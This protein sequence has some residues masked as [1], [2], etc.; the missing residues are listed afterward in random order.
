MFSKGRGKIG[1]ASIAVVMGLF[2]ASGAFQAAGAST[3]DAA[4]NNIQV[5]VQAAKSATNY[6]YTIAAYDSKGAL[7]VT[8][9]TMYPAAS[10]EVPSGAYTFTVIASQTLQS[11][12]VCYGVAQEK[13]GE[14]GA[15]SGSVGAPSAIMRPVCGGFPAAEYGFSVQQVTG[16]NTLTISTAPVDSLT[17]STFSIQVKYANGTAAEGVQ[18]SATILGAD[19][20]WP[21]SATAAMWNQTG[22]DGVATLVAPSAPLIVN[23]WSWLPVNLPNSITTIQ[24]TVG[25][26]KV[27]VT[28]YWQPTY[29]GLA[30]SALIMPPATGAQIILH[31]QQPDYWVQPYGV[32]GVGVASPP[33]VGRDLAAS[34]QTGVPASVAPQF[35]GAIQSP[36]QL[37]IPTTTVTTVSSAAE[38]GSSGLTIGMNWVTAGVIVA[39]ALAAS[40][41][42][43]VLMRGRTKSPA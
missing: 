24:T 12:N 28:V 5:F 41:F 13:S 36:P 10:F 14:V 30:G 4:Y 3:A 25:G 23:A 42:G 29:V 37:S 33:A 39:V 20:W 22:K 8:S 27:N 19:Y 16:P 18:L 11:P 31:A 26:E 9:Q 38:G 43:L 40:S 7:V 1:L 17:L 32:S 34:S 21:N 6:S 2:I 35:G 15:A